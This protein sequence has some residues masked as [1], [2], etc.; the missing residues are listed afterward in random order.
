MTHRRQWTPQQKLNI[1]LQGMS[2]NVKVSE[3]CNEH[4]ITQAMYY[5]WKNLLMTQGDIRAGRRGP[6]ARAP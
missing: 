4:G 1:V 3:L 2:G 6:R 5:E